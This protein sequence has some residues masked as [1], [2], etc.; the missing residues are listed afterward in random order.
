MR[1]DLPKLLLGTM[2]LQ[3]MSPTV[4]SVCVC[5]RAA[6]Q[7]L[8]RDARAHLLLRRAPGTNVSTYGHSDKTS[9]QLRINHVVAGCQERWCAGVGGVHI[10][11]TVSIFHATRVFLLCCGLLCVCVRART[12]V[13]SAFNLHLSHALPSAFVIGGSGGGDELRKPSA[14]CADRRSQTACAVERRLCELELFVHV[15][16]LP[17]ARTHRL[18]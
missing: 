16:A 6:R 7:P 15:N 2:R 3:R 11:K 4:R 5:A 13:H 17:C 1:T 9:A 8:Q 18:I 10:F 12:L 14:Q